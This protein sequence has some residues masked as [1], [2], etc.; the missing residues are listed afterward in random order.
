MID[1][2]GPDHAEAVTIMLLAIADRL[3]PARRDELVAMIAEATQDAT[4]LAE[5]DNLRAQ[6]GALWTVGQP[7]INA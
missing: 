1:A 7:T 5:L 3:A 4:L 6:L 2:I